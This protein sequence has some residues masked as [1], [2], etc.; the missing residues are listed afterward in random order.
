MQNDPQNQELPPDEMPTLNR[1]SASPLVR[2]L[3][4]LAD[5]SAADVS[6]LETIS[7]GTRSVAARTDLIREGDAPDGVYLILSGMACRYKLRESG[8]RQIMAY[9]V[10][11]DFCDL[12]VAMLKEMDHAIGTLS[13]C[14]VVQIPPDTVQDLLQNHPSITHA[15]RLATLVDEATLREWL[16]NVGCRS[17]EERIAHLLCELLLRLQE[18]GCA[19][20]EGYA[21]PLTNAD[22]ADTTGLSRVHVNR[23]LRSIGERGLVEIS[24]HYLRILDL[25]RLQALAE[26]KPNYLHLVRGRAA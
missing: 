22:L 16:V 23:T 25:P 4:S 14:E 8:A 10:P 2:K 1:K 13:D 18:V 17:A 12:D 20:S 3:K 5:V 19:T 11:G 7:G 15:L 6:A 21:F 9:L 24:D 26:F